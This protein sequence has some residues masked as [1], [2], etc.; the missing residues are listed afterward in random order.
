MVTHLKSSYNLVKATQVK[1]KVLNE[2]ELTTVKFS[3]FQLFSMNVSTF[4]GKIPNSDTNDSIYV[5]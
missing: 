5:F 2:D 3:F 4:F 1:A